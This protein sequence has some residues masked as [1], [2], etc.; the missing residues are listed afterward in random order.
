MER[1]LTS[2]MY[3]LF[4]QCSLLLSYD[5]MLLETQFTFC[6]GSALLL[7]CT[8]DMSTGISATFTEIQSNLILILLFEVNPVPPHLPFEFAEG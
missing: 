6:Q 7:I 5:L 2:Y 1:F 3:N 4:P 8:T